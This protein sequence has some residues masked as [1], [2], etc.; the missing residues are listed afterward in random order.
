MTPVFAQSLDCLSVFAGL[1]DDAVF[2]AFVNMIHKAS[3]NSEETPAAA[4]YFAARLYEK[5]EVSWTEYLKKKVLGCETCLAHYALYE[6]E[7]PKIM[8]DAAMNELKILSQAAQV[9]LDAVCFEMPLARWLTEPVDLQ[10]DYLNRLMDIDKYGYGML[11]EGKMF[12]VELESQG[13]IHLR[14]VIHP[15]PITF[16]QLYGYDVQHQTIIQNTAALLDKKPAANILLYGD[17]GTGKSATVKA[18][19]NMFYDQ[20]LRL[21]EVSKEQLKKLPDLLDL[22][23]M[24]PLKFIVFIDDLSFMENDDEFSALKAVLEGSVSAKSGNTVIYATSNRRHLVKET[25][26]SREGDDLHRNDSMQ[27]TISLSERFGLKVLFEKPAVQAYEDLVKSIALEKNIEMEEEELLA[28]AERFA[29]AKGGRS[30]RTARQF[31][32]LLE[33]GSE[34]VL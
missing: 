11:S 30:A 27:E 21:V 18:A 12:R 9:T 15:D 25:A 5:D 7:L 4:A 23:A 13:R 6:H 32:E 3:E 33:S 17:A 20:G 14:P 10:A 31:V 19:A 29:L 1:Y 34:A 26:A 28:R 16:D 24:Q 2:S 8:L 22:L